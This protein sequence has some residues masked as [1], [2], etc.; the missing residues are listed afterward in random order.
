MGK[1]P[2]ASAIRKR[3]E[4]RA[5]ELRADIMRELQKY[6]DDRY[7]LLADRVA[8]L[9]EQ[10][11]IHL[12]SDIDLAEISRDVDEYREI[13]AALIRLNSGSYGSC[14][15]CEEEIQRDRLNANPSASRCIG[16]QS[17]FERQ[18][19]EVHSRTL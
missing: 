8:D 6:D 7:N 11:L 1:Q 13:D 14:I 2:N 10:S 12:L 9:G 3:L 16:C 18:H 17:A 4:D 5:S 15:D 19:R